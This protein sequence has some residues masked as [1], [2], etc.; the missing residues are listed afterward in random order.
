VGLIAPE[1]QAAHPR[2]LRVDEVVASG[3]HSSIGL[4]APLRPA[5]QRVRGALARVAA[6]SLLR[7]S[8]SSLSYGQLRRVLFARALVNEPDMLLLDEP[9]AGLDPRQ[10]RALR[11][12]VERAIAAGVT[13]VIATHHVDEWPAGATHELELGGGQVLYAG[14]L[15]R[16]SVAAA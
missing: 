11:A 13:V 9:Y 2:H 10:R 14:P 3:L 16:L 15:R 7:R 5:R 4:D 1:L 6:V 8:V 12:L